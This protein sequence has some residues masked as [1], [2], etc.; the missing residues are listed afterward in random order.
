MI[1]FDVEAE[2]VKHE[3]KTMICRN[4]SNNEKFL[5]D[6]KEKCTPLKQTLV[7]STMGESVTQYNNT[8]S[9]LF[10]EHYP[11]RTKQVKIVPKAPWFDSREIN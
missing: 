5:E 4:F 6:V 2:A 11:P 9:Q 3:I 7:P 1:T 8:M 10:M